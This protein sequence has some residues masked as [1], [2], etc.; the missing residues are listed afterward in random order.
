LSL[1][2][3]FTEFN[4]FENLIGPVDHRTGNTGQ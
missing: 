1:G 2:R 4:I 3:E